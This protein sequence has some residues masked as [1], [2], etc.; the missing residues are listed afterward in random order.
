VVDRKHQGLKSCGRNAYLL[1]GPSLLHNTTFSPKMQAESQISNDDEWDILFLI[2]SCYDMMCIKFLNAMPNQ[3]SIHRS[4]VICIQSQSQI[5]SQSSHRHTKSRFLA[6][7]MPLIPFPSSTI[8]FPKAHLT[9][10]INVFLPIIPRL[11][12]TSLPPLLPQTRHPIEPNS[13]PLMALLIQCI[14][15]QWT[16][17]LGHNTERH[18]DFIGS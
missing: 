9:I 8:Q 2:I 13:Q 18:L 14:H 15:L 7:A 1:I 3:P 6:D 10:N 5:P 11:N 4:S 12:N 16:G 17:S